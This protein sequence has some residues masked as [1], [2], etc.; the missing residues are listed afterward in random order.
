MNELHSKLRSSKASL[1]FSITNNTAEK[2]IQ[3][4]LLNTPPIFLP[5]RSKPLFRSVLGRSFIVLV[6][7]CVRMT[8]NADQ[9]RREPL[10]VFDSSSLDD[11]V[12][13]GSS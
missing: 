6:L 8:S 5:A 11:F 13:C 2:R 9:F 3:G 1:I 10:A 12:H 7:Y 4:N